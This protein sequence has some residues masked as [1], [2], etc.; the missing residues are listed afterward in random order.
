MT[1]GHPPMWFADDY[2]PDEIGS[3]EDELDDF[4]C[5]MGPDGPLRRG[6]LRMV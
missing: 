2:D 4:D 1:G 5:H 3:D 6:W